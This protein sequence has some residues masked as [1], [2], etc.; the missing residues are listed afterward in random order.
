[1]SLNEYKWVNLREKPR[2]LAILRKVIKI[3]ILFNKWNA[4]IDIN[5]WCTD[6]YWYMQ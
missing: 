2:K 5:T 4:M 1:M 3:K 6:D